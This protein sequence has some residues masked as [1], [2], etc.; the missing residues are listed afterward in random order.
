MHVSKEI[1]HC[2]YHTVHLYIVK[3]FRIRINFLRQHNHQPPKWSVF[4]K[5]FTK[6]INFLCS[7]LLW[8]ILSLHYSL[9]RYIMS[10][11]Y[12]TLPLESQKLWAQSIVCNW[13]TKIH[14]NIFTRYVDGFLNLGVTL[15]GVCFSLCH[16]CYRWFCSLGWFTAD[17]NVTLT[18]SPWQYETA[19][20]G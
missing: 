10:T 18:G 15:C 19:F 1:I 11:V 14:E 5:F 12:E 9:D 8:F 13:N 6:I 20:D 3:L 17:S 7:P 4:I 2:R 16:V